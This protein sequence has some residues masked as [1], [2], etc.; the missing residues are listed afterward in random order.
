MIQFTQAGGCPIETLFG[1]GHS[2]LALRASKGFGRRKHGEFRFRLGA[3]RDDTWATGTCS[4]H[5][6]IP[7]GS[8]VA[9][10]ALVRKRIGNG[11]KL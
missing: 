7:G 11:Y 1:G 5:R 6:Q 8:T 4:F 9:T 10:A 2:G 3:S